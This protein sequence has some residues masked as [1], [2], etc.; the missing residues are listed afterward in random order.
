MAKRLQFIQQAQRAAMQFAGSKHFRS[1]RRQQQVRSQD[2]HLQQHAAS[3][4]GVDENQVVMGSEARQQVAQAHAAV[5]R[6]QQQGGQLASWIVGV[7]QV[8]AADV[9]AGYHLHAVVQVGGNQLAGSAGGFPRELVVA[10]KS[11]LTVEVH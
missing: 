2:R 8:Q 10:G 11:R 9:G 1:D 3:P 5:R 4:L 7:D 6:M